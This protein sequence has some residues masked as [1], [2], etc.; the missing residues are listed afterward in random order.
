MKSQRLR[1]KSVPWRDA[2]SRQMSVEFETSSGQTFICFAD[3][4][5]FKAGEMAEIARFDYLEGGGILDE[6]LDANPKREK[7][8][9]QIGEWN[10]A[11]K[12]QVVGLEGSTLLIDCG[13]VIFFLDAMTTDARVIGEWVGFTLERLEVERAW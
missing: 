3:G 13:G 1:V 10:V 9:E 12:G 2:G 4:G 11:A 8:I 6:I 5:E 7:R